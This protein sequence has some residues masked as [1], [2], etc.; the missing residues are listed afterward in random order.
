MK[1]NK[2]AFMKTELCQGWIACI[3][4]WDAA[5]KRRSKAQW[6]TPEYV[7]SCKA[8]NI[9][10]TQHEVYQMAVKQF[11]GV[12]YHF[13]RTDEYFGLVT[14]DEQDWLFRYDRKTAKGSETF[15]F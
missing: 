11:Y 8:S 3:T 10:G 7:D 2:E 13:S 1:M 12:E 9:C 15:I 6:G 5:I 14:E 4:N